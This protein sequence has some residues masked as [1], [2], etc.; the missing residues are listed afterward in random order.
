MGTTPKPVTLTIE[1]PPALAR[2]LELLCQMAKDDASA[3]IADA[4]AL[5]FDELH[6]PVDFDEL[7]V[8]RQ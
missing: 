4:L 7:Q 5:H 2:E 3:V 6:G 1:L 8:A